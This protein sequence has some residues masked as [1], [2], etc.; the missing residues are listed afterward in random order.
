ME[1]GAETTFATEKRYITYADEAETINCNALQNY[2]TYQ[3]VPEPLTL[4]EGIYKVQPGH[5]FIKKKNEPIHFY[6]YFHPV[7]N[8][9]DTDRMQMMKGIRRTLI[10][11]VDIHMKGDQPLGSFL[12]G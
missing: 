1:S 11:S 3:Y 6:R 2:L 4:T 9:V 8:P 10:N 7:F 5:Y 12:S